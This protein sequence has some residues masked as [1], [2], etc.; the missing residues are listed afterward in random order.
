ML[1]TKLIHCLIVNLMASEIFRSIVLSHLWVL[2]S[3]FLELF[4]I[5]S[6]LLLSQSTWIV[7]LSLVWIVWWGEK[8]PMLKMGLLCSLWNLQLCTTSSHPPGTQPPTLCS[9]TVVIF[10]LQLTI[11]LGKRDFID[12]IGSVEP[13]G[14]SISVHAA[15]PAFLSLII[16]W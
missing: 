15:L 16:L 12:N 5:R 11:Y 14:K 9:S 1:G 6:S 7:L 13:V 4:H 3:Y 2:V 8:K 10:S